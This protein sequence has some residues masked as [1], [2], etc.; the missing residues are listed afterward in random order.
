[1]ANKPIF[2]KYYTNPDIANLCCDV[3]KKYVSIKPDDVI[4]EPSAGN[5]SFISP[6]KQLSENTIFLDIKPENKEIVKCNFLK[7]KFK[8]VDIH[9]VGNPPFGFKSSLAIKFIKHSCSFCKTFAFILP[10]SFMKQS[11][12]A[13]VPLN[14][15][16]LTTIQL[17]NNSFYYKAT[18]LHI[19]CIFQIWEK[20]HYNRKQH[21]RIEPFMYRFTTFK[22]ADV[23]IRRVGHLAGH[24]Y[25]HDIANKNSNTHYFIEFEKKEYINQI[26]DINIR[27]NEYVTGPKSI[28]K[29]DIIKNLNSQIKRVHV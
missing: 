21:K 27:S 10:K 19:P 17:P 24:I 26:H 3:F 16:L 14:F 28:S 6:L 18:E 15:H 22:K 1:M 4:I 23:A 12:Q 11:M 5:G 8:S 25:K 7:T 13:T 20:R 9:V 29:K 2:D